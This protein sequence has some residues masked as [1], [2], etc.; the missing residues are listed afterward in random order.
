MSLRTR[1]VAT[2]VA[3]SIPLIAGSSWLQGRLDAR[4]HA[5]WL[6]EFATARMLDGGREAC[7]AD[8]VRFPPLRTPRSRGG[9]PGLR[10]DG[11]GGP[12]RGERP[13]PGPG[14]RPDSGYRPGPNL[15]SDL[16][17]GSGPGPEVELFAY[18]PEFRSA[19]P[20][21]PEFP[22]SLEQSLRTGARSASELVKSDNRRH[23]RV[24]VR[25]DWETGPC[26]ILLAWRPGPG[27]RVSPGQWVTVAS[28]TLGLLA[29]TFLAAGPLVARL[30]RLTE[31]VLAAS[32]SGYAHQVTATGNDEL[33]DLAHAFNRAGEEVREQITTVESRERAL[34][35]FVADTTHDV[36]TPMT[37]LHGHLDALRR[38]EG[39]D[40]AVLGD[41]LE[42]VHYMASLVSN[43]AAS[44][45]L[46]AGA[47]AP[48]R[49]PVDLHAL[50]ER[51]VARHAPIAREKGIELNHGLCPEPLSTL[52]DV[53]LIQQ[54][55]SNL[56]HNAVRYGR[57]GGHV[58]VLLERDGPG[59][60]AI[61]VVDDG[62]G[63]APEEL[64]SILA[65]S[66]RSD[67]ARSRHPEGQGLGLPIVQQVVTQHGF[68]LELRT[69]PDGGLEA[70]IRGDL[71]EPSPAG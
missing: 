31:E 28:V 4:D 11:P 46:V 44:A 32:E 40:P 58:A 19:N 56:V 71:D 45:K 29:A 51:V 61:R 2:L 21:A 62:P 57:P 68:E 25:M 35:E 39:V 50:V 48:E 13:G 69:A 10:P 8:P 42:E 5:R 27:P 26:A 9:G 55:A 14:G 53:T 24:A 16:G 70:V 59:R 43:L 65:R 12:P 18:D 37:V 1:L 17:P 7:E 36:M 47:R 33:T 15:G 64:E 67:E 54:A 30:R 23:V 41:A 20:R 3:L 66:G 38:T 60:F 52:G 63:V 22:A 34:R 49:N 6:I